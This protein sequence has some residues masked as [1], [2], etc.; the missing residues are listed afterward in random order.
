MVALCLYYVMSDVRDFCQ[1][2]TAVHLKLNGNVY[3]MQYTP[4]SFCVHRDA[5]LSWDC[6]WLVTFVRLR[7]FMIAVFPDKS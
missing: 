5:K 3:F 7:D 6:L 2:L 4:F 1:H